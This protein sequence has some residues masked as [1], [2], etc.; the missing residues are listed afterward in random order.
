MKT[1]ISKTIVKKGYHGWQAKTTVK[2]ENACDYEI[3]T[4][5]MSG[6][7]VSCSAQAGTQKDAKE[8]G[9]ESFGYMMFSDPSY[10]LAS[11]KVRANEKSISEIHA[12]GLLIFNQKLEAGEL[13]TEV[14]EV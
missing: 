6:G 5:K 4:S 8:G 14:A 7:F 12:A 13:A 2:I 11:K 1:V 3:S 9:L 10:K